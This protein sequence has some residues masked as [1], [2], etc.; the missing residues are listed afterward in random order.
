M[1][2]SRWFFIGAAATVVAGFSYG[3]ALRPWMAHWGATES[4]STR[5]FPGDEIVATPRQEVTHAITIDAAPSHV[6]PW[7]VQMGQD[8]G[9]LY[10]YTFLENLMGLD[11]Q[12]ADRIVP[13]WQ[14]LKEGDFLRLAPESRGDLKLLVEHIEVERLLLLRAPGERQE[15]I[16]AGLPW[17]SWAIVLEPVEGGSAT[18]L[19]FRW[20]TDFAP[21]LVGYALNKYA[22]EPIQFIMERKTML[23]IKERAERMAE[24]AAD[25]P[26]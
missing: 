19:I 12:N 6:W 23:G 3:F 7:V 13:E 4:E 1:T 8:K 17:T 14:G 26:P 2:W 20:R 25:A 16:D 18:R 11:F 24:A 5:P 15:A 21:T 10:S 9:G 22:I